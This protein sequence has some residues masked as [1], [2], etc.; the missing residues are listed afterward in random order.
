MSPGSARAGAPLTS[1]AYDSLHRDLVLEPGGNNERLANLA[2]PLDEHLRQIELRLGV[3]I[4][5]RG[6]LYRVIGDERNVALAAKLL[7]ACTR[8]RN[9]E[10]LDAH[11]INL[12]LQG[13]L[14]VGALAARAADEAQDVVI[15]VKRGTIKGRGPNQA[16]YLHAIATNDINFGI[17]PTGTGKT[18]SRGRRA[19]SAT[20]S[21]TIACSA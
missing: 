13:S 20:R 19:R 6:N 17:G 5:N 18:L 8:R 3:E 12:H 4:N 10:I 21:K 2:G 11:A 9:T 16:R 1:P 15:R 14:G 7:H